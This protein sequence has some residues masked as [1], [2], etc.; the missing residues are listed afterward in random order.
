MSDPAAQHPGLNEWLM[1][2]ERGVSSEAMVSWLV[3]GRTPTGSF[4][5][6]ADPDDFRRCENLLS[7]VP[8]LRDELPRMGELSTRWA[9]LV[10]R[11]G[12]IRDLMEQETGPHIWHRPRWGDKAPKAYALMQE[13]GR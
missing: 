6:P 11:W 2:G 8:T 9:G 3:Y 4:N 12:K 1:F 5:D 13:A 7:S 10:E